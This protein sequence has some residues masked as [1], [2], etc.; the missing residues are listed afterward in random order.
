MVPLLSQ[1]IRALERAIRRLEFH[2]SKVALYLPF[3]A[4]LWRHFHLN[5]SFL[6]SGLDP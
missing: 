2:L 3:P 5:S 1:E 4:L 6:E